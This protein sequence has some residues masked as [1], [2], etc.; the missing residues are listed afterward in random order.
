M[1]VY[2]ILRKLSPCTVTQF[3]SIICIH[4]TVIHFRPNLPTKNGKDS[5]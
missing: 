4:S 1:I 5:I 2:K 3:Y